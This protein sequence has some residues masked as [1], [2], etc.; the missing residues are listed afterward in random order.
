MH[1]AELAAVWRRYTWQISASAGAAFL[2]AAVWFSMDHSRELSP[3]EVEALHEWV[4]GTQSPQVAQLFNELQAD[5][6]VTVDESA[7]L[8]E[9][10]KAAPVP[11]G[12]YQP[13]VLD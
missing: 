6:V 7:L 10:A 13:V 5:D 2:A 11:A 4:K 12:L 8:A 1:A 9:E 3:R